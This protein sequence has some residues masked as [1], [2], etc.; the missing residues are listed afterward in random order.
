[1]VH[2]LKVVAPLENPIITKSCHHGKCGH[3][4]PKE[5]LRLKED[6]LFRAQNDVIEGWMH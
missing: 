3:D 5:I 6:T 2:R 4:Y 1:V